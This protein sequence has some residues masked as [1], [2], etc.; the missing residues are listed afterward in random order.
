MGRNCIRGRVSVML[1]SL[2]ELGLRTGLG[3]GLGLGAT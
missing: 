1:G 2:L 3:L